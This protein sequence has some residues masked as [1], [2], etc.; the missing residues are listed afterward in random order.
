[1]KIPAKAYNH[2]LHRPASKYLRSYT[3][4]F[5]SFLH[6]LALRFSFV[7]V[8]ALILIVLFHSL[9]LGRR[10]ITAM[11]LRVLLVAF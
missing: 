6:L 9:Q 4:S 1:M 8:F 3:D 11:S 5:D 2:R 7:N 10:H